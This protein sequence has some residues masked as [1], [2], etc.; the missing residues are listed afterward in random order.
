MQNIQMIK[1]RQNQNSLYLQTQ[2]LYSTKRDNVTKRDN[3]SYDSLGC[4]SSKPQNRSWWFQ[5]IG[6]RAVKLRI[7]GPYCA[8]GFCGAKLVLANTGNVSTFRATDLDLL[9]DLTYISTK[10]AKTMV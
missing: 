3:A 8:Q 7:P 5:C 9:I 1:R 10:L 2:L 6:W 4:K